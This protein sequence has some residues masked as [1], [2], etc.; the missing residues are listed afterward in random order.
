MKSVLV[1]AAA[2]SLA[3]CSAKVSSGG[4]APVPPPPSIDY[5][6]SPGTQELKVKGI[7]EGSDGANK[8][9]VVKPN[10]TAQDVNFT[11]DA[12]ETGKLELSLDGSME[13]ACT[14]GQLD[15]KKYYEDMTGGSVQSTTDAVGALPM[16]AGHSYRVRYSITA[17]GA[18]EA[19]EEDFRATFTAGPFGPVIP[20]DPVTPTTPDEPAA[21]NACANAYDIGTFYTNAADGEWC[22]HTVADPS[23]GISNH[24]S[25]DA[26]DQLVAGVKIAIV[27]GKMS[28]TRASSFC[29]GIGSGW[30][31]PLSVGRDASPRATSGADIGRSIEAVGKYLANMRSMHLWS[32]S[33][34]SGIENYNAWISDI[35][36]GG[37]LT[38]TS[39][40]S[41]WNVVCVK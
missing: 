38:Q 30:K 15:V 19:Y 14:G 24:A 25:I 5:T 26:A 3:S 8:V 40:T 39:L 23:T 11:V 33:G 13:V 34:V 28:F 31:L 21:H 9:V 29:A 12:K 1:L 22:E 27:A 17:A 18:C 35:A 20:S 16:I 10:T 2:I 6:P 41:R 37:N 4:S 36:G 32:G 7:T